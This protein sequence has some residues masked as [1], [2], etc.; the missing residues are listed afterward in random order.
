[1]QIGDKVTS[2]LYADKGTGT[3]LGFTDLFG[4]SYVELLF[5]NGEKGSTSV[6]DIVVVDTLVSKLQA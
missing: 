3:I 6:D 4:E 1:M 5:L 2:K